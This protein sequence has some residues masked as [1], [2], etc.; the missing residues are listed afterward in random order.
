LKVIWL[1]KTQVM[2]R[3]EAYTNICR[4]CPFLSHE[5]PLMYVCIYNKTD[6]NRYWI[7]LMSY[8][9]I[10]DSMLCQWRKTTNSFRIIVKIDKFI[11]NSLTLL[12]LWRTISMV[13]TFKKNVK[14][15][16]EKQRQREKALIINSFDVECYL[17]F[18]SY[19]T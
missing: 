3:S 1:D 7:T 18:N 8:N 11:A 4:I 14:R 16:T 6:S 19:W 13:F 17:F 12:W 5:I 15:E 9:G 10:K 2:K